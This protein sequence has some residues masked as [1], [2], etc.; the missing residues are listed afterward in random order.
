MLYWRAPRCILLSSWTLLS[1][2]ARAF[3]LR[4]RSVLLLASSASSVGDNSDGWGA[5]GDVAMYASIKGSRTEGRSE[6]YLISV[7]IAGG[8]ASRFVDRFK[9]CGG[10]DFSSVVNSDFKVLSGSFKPRAPVKR[11]NITEKD[12]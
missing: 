11:W 3:S 9:I 1:R 10:S 4:S 8:S 2:S 6:M 12:G 5:G 7:S